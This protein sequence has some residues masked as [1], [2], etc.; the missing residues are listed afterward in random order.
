MLYTG[1][2]GYVT[3]QTLLDAFEPAQRFYFFSN[4][5]E[6]PG[7]RLRCVPIAPEVP[8]ARRAK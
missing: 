7:N 3:R 8:T 4:Q 2:I 1:K 5:S 6:F